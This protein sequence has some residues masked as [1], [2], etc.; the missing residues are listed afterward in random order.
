MATTTLP[1][2]DQYVN[3]H[4]DQPEPEFVH[5]E[6]IQRSMPTAIHAWLAHLLSMRLHAAGFC[7]VTVR[8]RIA[9]DVI[10][11]PD[12]AVFREFPRDRAPARPPLIVVEIVSPDDRHGELLRKLS[13]Y[14]EWGVAHI[15]VVEPE[16]EK[17]FV[18]DSRGLWEV[19][20]FE[21]ANLRIAA[22]ELFAE[23]TAR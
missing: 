8:L 2:V 19:K 17:L 21:S 1:T 4:F 9:E 6:L 11:I 12:L 16:L 5:G 14:C 3:A 20:Q 10:R 22:E 18:Y 23:P 13:E 7:L 15:W